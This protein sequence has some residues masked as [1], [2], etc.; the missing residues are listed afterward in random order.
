MDVP[1]NPTNILIQQPSLGER[2]HLNL[3][4]VLMMQAWD[5]A[6]PQPAS[7]KQMNTCAELKKQGK[8][9]KPDANLVGTPFP[10]P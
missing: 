2:A 6:H 10:E 1:I 8:E 5:L 9:K 7:S 3:G 4:I